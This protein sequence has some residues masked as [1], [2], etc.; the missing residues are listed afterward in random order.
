M[1]SYVCPECNVLVEDPSWKKLPKYPFGLWG[2][3]P[4]CCVGDVLR[5]GHVLRDEKSRLYFIAGGRFRAFM[6]GFGRPWL[7]AI[8]AYVFAYVL[9]RLG[10]LVWRTSSS[11][12]S[13]FARE[14]GFGVFFLG[15]LLE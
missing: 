7:Y 6:W 8:G 5:V 13:D 12:G 1:A 11:G 3:L 14:C 10:D 9:E 4:T 2:T 15:A